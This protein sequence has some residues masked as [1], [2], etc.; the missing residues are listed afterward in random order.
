MYI[1]V[2]QDL[3]LNFHLITA[4][5]INEYSWLWSVL[6]LFHMQNGSNISLVSVEWIRGKQLK[7]LL[8]IS[9][10]VL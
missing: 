7:E 8:K 5:K 1:F 6:E 3:K 4:A 10:D 9:F 2:A